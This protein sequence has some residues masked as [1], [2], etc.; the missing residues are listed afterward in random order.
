MLTNP[1]TYDII[2]SSKK[3]KHRKE[4]TMS[5]ERMLDLMIR[6]YGFE[7]KQ[8]IEFAKAMECNL[9]DWELKLYFNDIYFNGDVT[10]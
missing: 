9:Q 5:A 3:G 6:R 1:G 7:A 10:R 2:K 8:T 4:K